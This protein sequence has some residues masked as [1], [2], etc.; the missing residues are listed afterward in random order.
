[1]VKKGKAKAHQP[2]PAPAIAGKDAGK[3]KN[4]QATAAG[5]SEELPPTGPPKPTVKQL[6][7]GASWTGKL[8]VNLLSEYCQKQK[9]DKP[10]YDTKKTPEGFSVWVTLSAKDL[11]TQQTIKLEPFKIPASHKHL[12]MRDTA[13]EAKHAAATYALF[14]VC[15]M[16]NKHMVL[17]PDHKALWKEFQTLKAQDVKDGKTAL[18]D[19]DPFKAYLEREEAKAAAEKKRKEI[20]ATRAKAQAMPGAS[21]LVL[22]D[23]S[24]RSSNAMKG[25][26]TAPKVE[27]GRQTRTQLESLLRQGIAWNPHEVRMPKPQKDKVIEELSK[28]GFRRSHVAEAVDYCKDREETLEWLLIHVPEDD[29]PRWALPESY[30]AGVSFGAT[31]LRRE[32]MIKR[33]SETGYSLELCT[34]VVDA[35]GGDEGKAAEQLQE[36]L[37]SGDDTARPREDDSEDFL[38]MGSP[39]EQWDEEIASLEAMYGEIFSR[40]EGG[41]IQ[42]QLGKFK[43]AS[44][45]VE[46][47]LQVRRSPNYPKTL[48]LAIVAKL[49]SYI[50]LSIVK[51]T[52]EHM[53]ESL[54]DEPMKIFLVVDWLQQNMNSIIERFLD[55]A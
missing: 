54:R 38:D 28:I 26:M 32:G 21:G 53:D 34:R 55:D 40:E 50:K 37:C 25:W 47:S 12:L 20:E 22:M 44:Q 7:G 23:G 10:V 17:P 13:I 15:S 8:P 19:A 2:V 16:Q 1:M 9:W 31:D 14:R 45:D 49:P 39:E 35:C 36:L 11:K 52:L 18:Y 4:R 3:G 29:L 30:S 46:A 6:I 51:K 27:M 24:S 42:I 48:L 33:L 41:V 5:A 43:N